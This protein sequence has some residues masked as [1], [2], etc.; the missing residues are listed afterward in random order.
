[1]RTPYRARSFFKN[2]DLLYKERA[3]YLPE[4]IPQYTAHVHFFTN[5]EL[6]MYR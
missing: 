6:L 3:R 2:L 4:N 5:F 1:M